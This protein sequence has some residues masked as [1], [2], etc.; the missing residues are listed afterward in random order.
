VKN[1]RRKEHV[2]VYKRTTRGQWRGF[3]PNSQRTALIRRI[4]SS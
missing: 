2:T 3:M 1:G 4:N